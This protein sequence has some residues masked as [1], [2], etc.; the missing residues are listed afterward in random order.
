MEVLSGM[1]RQLE[2][3]KFRVIWGPS[4]QDYTIFTSF[5]IIDSNAFHS[6]YKHN[7]SM[8]EIHQ[9]VTKSILESVLEDRERTKQSMVQEL[10]KVTF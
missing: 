3:M 9:A 1:Q 8:R 4:Y 10:E 6:R 2:L 5:P 7:V